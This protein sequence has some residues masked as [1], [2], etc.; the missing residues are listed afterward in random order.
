MDIKQS[1]NIIRNFCSD[2]ENKLLDLPDNVKELL[3]QKSTEALN[4]GKNPKRKVAIKVLET[5]T[6]IKSCIFNYKIVKFYKSPD[7]SDELYLIVKNNDIKHIM[8]IGSKDKD[9][10]EFIILLYNKLLNLYKSKE[11]LNI[12]NIQDYCI[13]SNKELFQYNKLNDEEHFN[14]YV[15]NKY[16]V[17]HK[18]LTSLNYLITIFKKEKEIEITNKNFTNEHLFELFFIILVLSYNNAEID[19]SLENMKFVEYN[20]PLTYKIC[21]YIFTIPNKKYNIIFTNIMSIPTFI[22]KNYDNIEEI[23]TNGILEVLSEFL[24]EIYI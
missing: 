9:S 13:I 12:F 21:D 4:N 24:E 10:L 23:I 3:K 6:S 11:L 20:K 5:L 19:I 17:S 15:S 1:L 18:N 2:K 16:G 7:Y 22:P 8:S 14:K